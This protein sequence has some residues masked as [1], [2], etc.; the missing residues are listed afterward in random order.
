MIVRSAIARSQYYCPV[1]ISLEVI[2]ALQNVSGQGEEF[3]DFAVFHSL[4]QAEAP[5][6]EGPFE[7]TGA[8]SR[9]RRLA[10]LNRR[11]LADKPQNDKTTDIHVTS[12][13]IQDS[14]FSI[15]DSALNAES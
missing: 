8:K 2:G 1:H 10:L 14:A 11:R 12:V 15:Q 5:Q 4:L 3:V 6:F 13:S 7:L 9:L